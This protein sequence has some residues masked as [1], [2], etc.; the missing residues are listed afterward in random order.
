M[1]PEST[2]KSSR[3][4]VAASFAG[5]TFV[6]ALFFRLI[7]LGGSSMGYDEIV[8]TLAAKGSLPG[9]FSGLLFERAP[10]PLGPLLSWALVGLGAGET[11]RRLVQAVLAAAAVALFVRWV[12]R[13]A[14]MATAT[15]VALFLSVSPV[16]VRYAHEL[17]PYA[18]ALLA[19][20]WALD[21]ADRWIARGAKTIPAELAVA[22]A[23]A[24]LANRL[25]LVVV[26]PIAA[27][28]L[29]GRLDGRVKRAFAQNLLFAVPVALA[30]C[31][32]WLAAVAL[33]GGPP[34]PSPRAPWTF[35]EIERRFEDLLLRGYPGQPVV[36]HALLLFASLAVIGMAVLAR[37]RGGLAI[38]AG[39]VAGTL[40]VELAVAVAGRPTHLHGDLLGLLFLYVA[41]AAAVAAFAE[42]VARWNR[43]SGV[44]AGAVLTAAVGATSGHGLVGYAQHGRP[45]WPAVARAVERL[46]GGGAEVVVGQRAAAVAL[47]YYLGRL[48]G[49][50]LEPA[51]MVVVDGDRA[52]L[53][54]AL[55]R[56][57]GCRLVLAS[58]TPPDAQLVETLRPAE[59]VLRLPDTDAAELFRIA[60]GGVDAAECRAPADFE[61]EPTPGYGALLPWIVTTRRSDAV[62]QSVP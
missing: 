59:P 45:D 28:W 60:A 50:S 19:A 8:E 16:L 46:D 21:A 42:S 27:A 23:T 35:A 2:P 13:R 56:V 40:A 5:A 9:L 33:R 12:E 41:I 15:T 37:R 47:G 58:E 24:G 36:E 7:G 22:V 25:S 20:V 17:G 62:R 48:D 53:D 34:R 18:L 6:A 30:P 55:A 49:V 52:R 11:A 4:L 10:G 26:L 32:L 39:L 54:G 31:G 51:G 29:E 61:V 14:G 44:I 57:P 1:R 3:A 43:A 38:L